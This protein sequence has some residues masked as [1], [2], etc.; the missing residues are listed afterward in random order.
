[1]EKLEAMFP[2]LNLAGAADA[3][4]APAAPKRKRGPKAD[5][6]AGPAAKKGKLDAPTKAED[7]ELDASAKAEDSGYAE[8]SGEYAGLGD[9]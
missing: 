3:E 8:L 5:K 7:S 4:A 9:E 2:E 6:K 1:M